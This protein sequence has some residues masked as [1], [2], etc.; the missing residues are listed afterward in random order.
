MKKGDTK[1]NPITFTD[2]ELTLRAL[3]LRL[4]ARMLKVPKEP[5][6]P[7]DP[8]VPKIKKRVTDRLNNVKRELEAIRLDYWKSSCAY[9]VLTP[10]NIIPDEIISTLASEAKIRTLLDIK[11]FL[12][13]WI[14]AK[15][16]GPTVL[17]RI[18]VV[19]SAWVAQNEASKKQ[20]ADDRKVQ[21]E[22]N[23]KQREEDRRREKYE[24]NQKKKQD[25]L[26]EDQ[27]NWKSFAPV[28]Q[29]AAGPSTLPQPP[30]TPVTP[31]PRSV[32]FKPPQVQLDQSQG[33]YSQY[34]RQYIQ[35]LPMVP[36]MPPPPAPS[37]P[38]GSTPIPSASGLSTPFELQHSH[39]LPPQYP[40]YGHHVANSPMVPTMASPSPSVPA[41]PPGS[42]SS[43]VSPYWPHYPPSQYQ[44]H[45]LMHLGSPQMISTTQTSPVTPL[46][47]PPPMPTASPATTAYRSS[48]SLSTPFQRQLRVQ[49]N[50]FP[51]TFSA[52]SGSPPYPL[53]QATT[54]QM[55]PTP[56]ITPITPST[57]TTIPSTPIASSSR[58]PHNSIPYNSLHPG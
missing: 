29:P 36:M 28:Q 7:A 43:P 24:S 50:Q 49:T 5:A 54:R 21:S 26:K 51:F 11:E 42:I 14:F 18:E 10:A 19:D 32:Q 34:Y 16:L 37:T 46:M 35:H 56:P 4:D 39:H 20:R 55:L 13:T 30:S 22:Q 6:A 2:H 47:P 12:P 45:P 52:P 33:Q 40:W 25:K 9:T 58:L 1:D 27:N 38:P 44:G 3:I 57:S 8:S 48:S 15:E 31:S 53:Q 17:R 23:K 41:V